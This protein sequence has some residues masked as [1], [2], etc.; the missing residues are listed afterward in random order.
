MKEQVLTI[1]TSAPLVSLVICTPPFSSV[2]SMISASTRF[3]AQPSEINPTRNGRSMDSCVITDH[4]AYGMDTAVATFQSLAQRREIPAHARREEGNGVH[5]GASGEN[6]AKASD[7]SIRG[8]IERA[9][10]AA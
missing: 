10:T 4:S 7:C 8:W 2:P 5:A 1:T 6:M 9:L 3:L